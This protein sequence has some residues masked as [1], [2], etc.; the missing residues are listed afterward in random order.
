MTSCACNWPP[1]MW[2]LMSTCCSWLET[3][4]AWWV[5]TWQTLSTKR[6]STVSVG[7]CVS[8]ECFGA[9]RTAQ[10]PVLST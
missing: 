6:S 4:P 9:V 1:R 5:L 10:A 8:G 7:V 2:P 3:C